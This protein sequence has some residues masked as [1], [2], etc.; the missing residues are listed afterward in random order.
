[1]SWGFGGLLKCRDASLT[2]M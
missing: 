1:M 2:M